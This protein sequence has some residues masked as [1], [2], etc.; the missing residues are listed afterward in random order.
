MPAL[1]KVEGPFSTKIPDVTWHR[2]QPE[3]LH[4]DVTIS[5]TFAT[6][7]VLTLGSGRRS[8]QLQGLLVQGRIAALQTQLHVAKCHATG[9]QECR[10][11]GTYTRHSA[12]HL[13]YQSGAATDGCR[14][15]ELW[16]DRSLPYATVNHQK[17]CFQHDHVHV[18][19]YSDRHLLVIVNA[20][21]FH[22]RILVLH[23]PY[24]TAS[25]VQCEQWWNDM[26][27]LVNRINPQ[28]VILGDCNARVGRI[29]SVAISDHG[30]EDENVPGQSMHCFMLENA[31]W[32]PATFPSCHE[33]QI[34]TWESSS[35]VHHRL[36][37]VCLPQSWKH[38]EVESKVL[39]DVDLATAKQ[40]HFVAAVQVRMHKVDSHRTK[41]HSFRVDIRRCKDDQCR[42]NFM[43]YLQNP[44]EFPWHMG[45]GE[46]TELLTNWLQEGAQRCFR[47]EKRLPRQRYLSDHTWQAIQLRKQLLKLQHASAKQSK[48][49]TLC[50]VF[51]SWR[52]CR[53]RNGSST[54]SISCQYVAQ[55]KQLQRLCDHTFWW[56]LTQRRELHPTVRHLSKQDRISTMQQILQEFYDCAQ[57][58][59][60]KRLY[61][62]LRP[63]LGQHGRQR[64][65]PFRPVPAVRDM[66]GTLQPDSTAAAECWRSHFANPE[67]G[68]LLDA[69]SLQS[70]AIRDYPVYAQDQLSF[71]YETVPT[72]SSIEKFILQARHHK[73]PGIDGLPAEI[74]QLCPAVFAR[75]LWPILLKFSLRCEEPMRWKGGEICALPKSSHPGLQVDQFRSILLAD[76][77]SKI[78]HG[79]LRQ[80]ILPKYDQYRLNMQGGGIPKF[81]TDM[82]IL[83]VQSFS[84]LCRQHHHSCATLY[85]DIKQ[86]FYRTC[87][88]LLVKGP[89]DDLSIAQFFHD[90]GWSAEFYHAFQNHV[91][92]QD[93]LTAAH[94]SSHQRAQVRSVLHATWFQIR[95]QPATL[96]ATKAGTKPGDSIADLLYG[97]VMARF[98]KD[99]RTRFIAEDLHTAFELQW[100]PIGP[101]HAG[102]IPTQDVVQGCW[103]DDLV[104]LL[105]E[106][107]PARLIAN[108]RTAI[109]LTYDLALEYKLLLNMGPNKTA[110]VIQFRGEGTNALW[111]QLLSP[112][113]ATPH[114]EFQSRHC[115]T[116]LRLDLVPD[117]VYLGSLQDNTGHPACEVKRRIM[118]AHAPQAMLRKN[119]FKSPKVPMTTKRQLFRSLTMSR[120]LYGSGAWQRMHI[121][122][123]KSWT[124]QVLK[125][126]Q[127]LVPQ[128]QRGPDVYNLDI[129]ARSQMAHPL[130]LLAQQR[131]S[132]FDRIMQQEQ[133]EL[134]AVLQNQCPSTGWFALI[135]Q[136]LTLVHNFLDDSELL[137][138]GDMTDIQQV[139]HYSYQHPHALTKLGKQV[140]KLHGGY[141][142]I[143]QDFRRF[144]QHLHEDLA[145]FHVHWYQHP[146]TDIQVKSFDCRLCAAHFNSYQALCAHAFKKHG[147]S[148]VA[149]KYAIGTTCRAC[150]KCYND[151]S[152]LVNHLKYFRTGCL[153]KL[154]LCVSPLTEEELAELREDESQMRA[155]QRRQLRKA[156]HP[157]P[158]IQAAGP[159][160]PWPWQRT[161]MTQ[162]RDS[163]PAPALT[164][165][166]QSRWLSDVLV[167]VHDHSIERTYHALRAVPFHDQFLDV[168]NAGFTS[169]SELFSPA[170]VVDQHLILQDA[171]TLWQDDALVP[172]ANLA[173]F[174]STEIR[175]TLQDICLP[176]MSSMSQLDSVESRRKQ[177]VETIWNDYDVVLQLRHQIDKERHRCYCFPPIVPRPFV[178]SPVFLYMFSGRRR[179]FDYQYHL[180]SFLDQTGCRGTVL[181]LDLAL[182]STH[183]VTNQQLVNDLVQGLRTGHIAAYLVAPPCETWSEIR[184]DALPHTKCPRPVRSARDPYAIPKLTFREL[185]QV[186]VANFLLYVAVR[187]LTISALSGVPGICERPKP[188]R[189]ESRASI[190][191]T[192]WIQSMLKARIL[193]KHV[194]LQAKYGASSVKP[195]VFATCNVKGFDLIAARYARPVQW[196]KLEKLEGKRE[197][198]SWK[199]AAAKEYPPDLNKVLACCH[200]QSVL[201]AQHSFQTCAP[202]QERL[203]T[204]FETLSRDAMAAQFQS[205]Q[206]DYGHG[207][208]L[209]E[210]D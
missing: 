24:E 154:V 173:A 150:L 1:F 133:V 145:S 43:Q 185:Q 80:R 57:S 92:D 51:Q 172:R 116:T 63:L 74:Y 108:L 28:L 91:Y 210:L 137:T 76:F 55:A 59:D 88:P 66:H 84:Q 31:M 191:R 199:T 96:T 102:D 3:D 120:V 196:D 10:T 174:S 35:G 208:Q 203:A 39:I 130:L 169:T 152:R 38:F 9:L 197:D 118:S 179:A 187:L 62:A 36:D 86:A 104:L 165:E 47:A 157:R 90:Q 170:E 18:S 25:D 106:E 188:S 209:Q 85:V 7:N 113:H 30:A 12:S 171:L 101:I 180:E 126:Y 182:S 175:M 135:L 109:Q 117:Y 153:L 20:P 149:H 87:R 198:G 45:I 189:D 15:C 142:R 22:I 111:Q 123:L 167:A 124:S 132:L 112:E 71:D 97:F 44:P 29:T 139:A 37:Y 65:Q 166:E 78:S 148:K 146:L 73:S 127:Q 26:T 128:V 151:R 61:S 27:I 200:V 183:D 2:P 119:V 176:P 202:T 50:A 11:V 69:P 129:L 138:W 105:K 19:S 6:A 83:L 110:A 5:M 14:G 21:H 75:F 13:V 115:Q 33:G 53:P 147:L 136:D 177:L 205:M 40:D 72:L 192:P 42:D 131:F 98:L 68:E 159:V 107:H 163:R 48:R 158:A 190:W 32:I 184:Y 161:L 160:R 93:A 56:A 52:T 156:S 4:E 64:Y 34:H 195:T 99:L 134:L 144:Q 178:E 81:G 206:P 89:Q 207:V 181:C 46:H 23:G 60:S 140:A 155:A 164:P 125:L 8:Q 67:Q 82:L 100:L 204:V 79:V 77:S 168:V 194:I 70:Q 17:F 114:L 186:A 49:L 143:W 121:Q 162:Q 95:N 54:R 141:L 201:A 94:V 122:T 41:L 16:L 193:H 103:V 58:H